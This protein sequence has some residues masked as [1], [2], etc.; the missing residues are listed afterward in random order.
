M[1]ERVTF[2]CDADRRNRIADVHVS[3]C[4]YYFEAIFT[5]VFFLLVVLIC[6]CAVVLLLL[7]VWS[8]CLF[9]IFIFFVLFRLSN[10][11]VVCDL[12][13]AE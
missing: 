4:F 9:F 1:A 7:A 13:E 2:P 6:N 12:R 8:R 5:L 3:F 10:T 11:D